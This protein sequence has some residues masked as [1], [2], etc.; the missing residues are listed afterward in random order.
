MKNQLL[1]DYMERTKIGQKEVANKLGVSIATV[2]LYL[3]G[4][5][6]GNVEELNI[7]VEQFLARQK[8]KVLEYK[9]SAEFVPTFTARQI[10]ATIQEAHI[11]G[12][13]CAVYGA[14]GLGK[15]QAVL[16]YAKENTGVILIET[17]MSYTAKVLLQKISEKL[18]LSNR[19]T[20]DQLFDGIVARLKGSERVIIIDE[21]ENLPTRSLEFI[22]RIHDATKVGVALVGTERL[23]INLKGRHNDLAQVYN[24]IWRASSLGNALPEKDLHLLTERA[25]NTGEYNELFF[26]HSQGNARR[27]NKLIRG[28]VRLSH[29]NECQIDERLIKEYTKMLIS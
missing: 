16:Q 22:R 1:K 21:A 14:S 7:K 15:T 23:L 5:Y 8:D 6:D 11:E 9:V 13:M 24:R 25:L 26:K 10:M 4:E 12:D 28:V 29:I 27:L 20:L 17:N 18:N 2:S 3:R 19:G